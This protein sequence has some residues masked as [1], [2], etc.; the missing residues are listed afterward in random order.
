[1][2]IQIMKDEGE[3]RNFIES[4][5]EANIYHT[6]EWRDIIAQSYGF[7]PKYLLAKE[8]DKVLGVLPLFEVKTFL[9]GKRL[10][11]IPFSHYVK[12]LAKN[13]SAKNTL[14]SWVEEQIKQNTYKYAELRFGYEIDFNPSFQNAVLNYNTMLDLN[15]PRDEI[16][17]NFQSSVKRA[18]RKAVKSEVVIK[19]TDKLSDYD[20]FYELE[21]ETRKKQGMPIYPFTFFRLLSEKLA[22]SQ[23]C[24][25]YLA[26]HNEVPI[27][28][29]II[30]EYNKYAIYGY[31]ASKNNPE[32]QRYRPTN[33]LFWEAI[34]QAHERG[35]RLFDF[36]TSP[37]SNEGLL[38]FK[39]RW[40]TQTEKLS[41]CFV[42][43][44]GEKPFVERG[45]KKVAVVSSI[46]K[47][48]PLPLFKAIGPF[49]L[50]EGC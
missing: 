43:A 3:Y 16:W 44:S 17:K 6:L 28:G 2:N 37:L 32:Y 24:R 5:P 1:M 39:K 49:L 7:T 9:R 40:G 50:R 33:L 20:I 23:K 26:Y 38:K 13:D 30:L 8:N 29:V 19:Q 18:I 36:G 47:K 48:T 10:I 31:G 22:A 41:Y 11:S 46:L 45:S 12:F 14:L 35:N 27:S 21:A 34:Q 15:K 4:S 42:T 25:L